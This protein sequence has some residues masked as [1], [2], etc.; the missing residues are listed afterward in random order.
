MNLKPVTFPKNTKDIIGN[1]IPPS[2]IFKKPGKGDLNY[3]SITYV[4]DTLNAAFGPLGWSWENKDK[5]VTA[6]EAQFKKNNQYFTSPKEYAHVNEKGEAGGLIPQPPIVHVEG[7]LTVKLWDED[8]QCYVESY[9]EACGS[10]VLVGGASDQDSAYKSAQS[11]AMKKAAS[12]FGV[13]LELARKEPEK[14]YFEELNAEPLEVVWT[15]E[16]K[17]TYAT[18][19]EL[20]NA[21]IEA[22]G[23]SISDLGYYVHMATEGVFSELEYMA[24]EYMPVLMDTLKSEGLVAEEV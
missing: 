15:D 14:E 10:K 16:L 12:F 22:N 2:V 8:R 19:W 17:A 11:D 20:I 13:G 6:S 4:T 7:R 3:I 5:W 9:R 23:W 18:E 1:P 21:I 24:E